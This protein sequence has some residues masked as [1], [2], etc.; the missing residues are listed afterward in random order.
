MNTVDQPFLTQQRDPSPDGL[1][2]AGEGYR[3]PE[4]PCLSILLT[5]IEDETFYCFLFA[6]V[7]VR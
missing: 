5:L 3:Y 4:V 1:K 6:S 7:L 2:P